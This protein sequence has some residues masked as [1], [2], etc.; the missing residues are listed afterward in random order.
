MRTAL[1]IVVVA[2]LAG[3]AFYWWLERSGDGAAPSGRPAGAAMVVDVVTV[4]PVVLNQELEA[5]GTAVANESITL[6]ANVSDTVRRVNFEDGD[7]VSEGDVLIELTRVEESSQLDE[8]RVA[9]ADAERRLARLRDMGARRLVSQSDIDDAE[10]ALQAARARLNTVQARLG[11]RLITAP[12]DG[13]LGF[14][15]VSVG[16]LVTPGTPITTL[17]D[18]SRIKVDFT[19]PEAALGLIRPGDSMRATTVSQRDRDFAGAVQTIGSRVD[20]VSRAAQ[21]RAVL[22]NPD[23]VLKPGM[24]LSVTVLVDEHEGLE[25]PSRA[26][27]QQ[28]RDAYLF[29]VDDEGFARRRNVALGLRHDGA[30]EIVDGLAEG[31]HVITSGVVNL[32]DG[33]PVQTAVAGAGTGDGGASGGH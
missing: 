12:F 5:L 7:P 18:I 29:V 26:V 25:V 14:R 8:A 16:T 11:D 4:Q 33:M 2:T 24:L 6:T 22:D 30:V 10:A 20:P 27:T 13:L 23:G 28:G 31:E 19:I 32:R 1:T 17:D 9:V 3:S 15:E 21:V